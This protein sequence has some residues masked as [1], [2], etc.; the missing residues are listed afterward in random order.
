MSHIEE[1][2][3]WRAIG[4]SLSTPASWHKPFIRLQLPIGQ[5]TGMHLHVA[6]QTAA[7]LKTVPETKVKAP[8]R[9][10]AEPKI[11]AIM[12]G[13]SMETASCSPTRHSHCIAERLLTKI[14]FCC[15]WILE[16]A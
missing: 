2:R 12:F 9:I 10:M 14:D 8:F 1:H 13:F 4:P 3:I 15:N 11:S 7:S 5:L 6:D 16:G